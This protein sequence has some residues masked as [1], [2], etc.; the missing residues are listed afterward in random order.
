MAIVQEA[1]DIPYKLDKLIKAGE[2][3]RYGGILRN[4][5]GHIVKHLKTVNPLEV[6][7]ESNEDGV[8]VA[9]VIKD[10]KYGVFIGVIGAVAA[11]GLYKIIKDRKYESKI[12]KNS[13]VVKNFNKSLQ[14]Y[15][16]AV[17]SASLDINL[18]N[19]L[20]ASLRNLK[21]NDNYENIKIELL[22]ENFDS[23]V[24]LIYEYTKKLSIDNDTTI[25]NHDDDDEKLGKYGTIINLKNSLEIQKKIFKTAC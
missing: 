24:N 25:K 18:I 20:L 11:A 23:M 14:N 9:K 3:E 8:K 22:T 7:K 4:N 5:K 17:R 13:E 10:N 1:F 15:L 6:D 19:D 21:A 2:L 16:Q 12:Q